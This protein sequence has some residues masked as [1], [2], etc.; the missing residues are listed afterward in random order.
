MFALICCFF[1]VSCIILLHTN[2]TQTYHIKRSQLLQR[3]S[4][5]TRRRSLSARNLQIPPGT[6]VSGIT[7]RVHLDNKSSNRLH[8][9]SSG[10]DSSS[11]TAALLAFRY[12]F[13][14]G[15][16]GLSSPCG[17]TYRRTPLGGTLGS[18]VRL[19]GTHTCS[20][21]HTGRCSFMGSLATCERRRHARER[22]RT[23][24]NAMPCHA[25]RVSGLLAMQLQPPPH[26]GE[27]RQSR[28]RACACACACARARARARACARA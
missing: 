2:K 14:I 4:S 24:C 7:W 3:L 22:E 13:S 9:H 25:M 11:A 17:G 12:C 6:A 28:G 20:D 21:F 26:L 5:S 10:R 16:S 19:V 23:A 8:S 18:R 1:S 27:R 15:V